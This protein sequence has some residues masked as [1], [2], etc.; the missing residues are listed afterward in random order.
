MERP[1]I[2]CSGVMF[3]LVVTYLPFRAS[4][5]SLLI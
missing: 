4:S 1:L 5:Q 3:Y 2:P